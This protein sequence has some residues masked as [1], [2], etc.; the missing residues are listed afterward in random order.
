MDNQIQTMIP[1]TVPQ[2]DDD[3]PMPLYVHT[4]A[5]STNFYWTFGKI[6]TFSLQTTFR[7]NLQ[8]VEIE[9]HLAAVKSALVHIV[10]M[11]GHAKPVGQQAQASQPAP[12][13]TAKAPP[14][15][16]VKQP[17]AQQNGPKE[18]H[19][20]KFV[21]VE[22]VPKPDGKSELRFYEAG[23]KYPDIYATRATEKWIDEL[24]WDET[25][26]VSAA[27]DAKGVAGY[28]LSDKL[29]TKGNPYKDIE[30]IKLG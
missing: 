7:G 11:G 14:T 27:Y 9:A 28:V 10:E 20:L 5:A 26:F 3:E 23:H 6:E 4:E 29:N 30:Y 24:G 21:K 25:A 1:S 2:P 17:A 8:D 18:I 13:Q 22:V 19:E 16:P 12:Q 15:P